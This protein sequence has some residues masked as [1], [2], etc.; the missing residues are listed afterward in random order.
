MGTGAQLEMQA[1]SGKNRGL[2]GIVQKSQTE[3]SR[4]GAISGPFRLEWFCAPE[5][6]ELVEQPQMSL[7]VLCEL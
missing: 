4:D 7:C 1:G 5:H 3:A 6:H 2:P